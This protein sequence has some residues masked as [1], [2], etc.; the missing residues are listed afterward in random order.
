MKLFRNDIFAPFFFAAII[1]AAA[2]LL[3]RD[4]SRKSLNREILGELTF[5]SGTVLRQAD[6]SILSETLYTGDKIFNKDTI[7]TENS[8]EGILYTENG[9]RIETDTETVLS[10]YSHPN[11][12][13]YKIHLKEGS[14]LIHTPDAAESID[15]VF[16]NIQIKDLNGT[17][18]FSKTFSGLYAFC[19]RGNAKII[20]EGDREEIL[21]EG[22]AKLF[23]SSGNIDIPN[24]SDRQPDANAHFFPENGD[25]TIDFRWKEKNVFFE[26]STNRNFTQTIFHKEVED[27]HLS[28]TLPE[29]IYYWRIQNE[30]NSFSHPQKIHIL[31]KKTLRAVSPAHESA[32][33]TTQQNYLIHFSWENHPLA[34]YFHLEI[35]EDE[36]FSRILY[37]KNIYRNG[38]ALELPLKTYYWRVSAIRNFSRASIS[39]VMFFSIEEGQESS[40]TEDKES[41]RIEGSPSKKERYLQTL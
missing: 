15:V 24:P 2:F 40:Y 35:S 7:L 28:F 22:K 39:S 30:K 34:E 23:S 8:S 37:S 1:F 10:L 11:D 21:P 17:F 31:R 41:K 32:F 18:Q 29:G 6:S 12:E 9:I 14:L 20:Y 3:Y 5:R 36:I 16:E 27:N 26:I 13:N 4:L 25:Q 38:I 19:S 33:L